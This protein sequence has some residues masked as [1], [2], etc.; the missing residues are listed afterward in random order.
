[1]LAGYPIAAAYH[2]NLP[3]GFSSHAGCRAY[4]CHEGARRQLLERVVRGRLRGPIAAWLRAPQSDEWTPEVFGM[5]AHMML[6]DVIGEPAY[7]QWAYADA[8]SVYDRPFVRHLMRLLSPSLLVMGGASRWGAM[9]SGTTLRVSWVRKTEKVML[10]EVELAY[11]SGLFPAPYCLAL[12][13]AFRAALDMAHASCAKVELIE[14]AA[15][16]SVFTVSWDR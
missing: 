3:A 10:A 8:R 2:A 4:E 13:E 1:M 12:G 16:R 9:H 11:P 7:L 6:V 14:H 5:T 15:E